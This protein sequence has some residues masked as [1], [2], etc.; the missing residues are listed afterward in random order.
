MGANKLIKT[1]SRNPTQEEIIII[2]ENPGQSF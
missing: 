1:L 2:E